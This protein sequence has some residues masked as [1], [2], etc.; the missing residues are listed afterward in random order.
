MFVLGAVWKTIDLCHVEKN[1]VRS[2]EGVFKVSFV[3]VLTYGGPCGPP[4]EKLPG[5]SKL[6]RAEGPGF[7]DFY[8]DLVLHVSAKNWDISMIR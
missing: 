5:N 6:V 2:G 7:W 4:W 8:F 1:Q 3:V